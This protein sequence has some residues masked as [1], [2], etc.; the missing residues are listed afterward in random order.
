MEVGLLILRVTVGMLV[1][2][3]GCQKLFGWFGAGHREPAQVEFER[4]GYRPAAV[5][6]VAA[7]M[8]ELLGGLMLAAGIGTAL[9][10][11]LVAGTAVQAVVAVKLRN[12]P[13]IQDG[14]YE[15]LMVLAVAAL[16][17]AFTGPGSWALDPVLGLDL[18]GAG[19]GAGAT[20]AALLAAGV[21]RRIPFI[22]DRA[23]S[24]DAAPARPP[25]PEGA[26]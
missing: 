12:G 16:A 2:A 24:A 22:G 21:P 13:W 7:G 10:A 8:T 15:Y 17:L 19:W 18:S 14:G 11:A 9:A 4:Y 1:A 3:H 20:A 23:H 5:F 25:Y 6:A 26:P